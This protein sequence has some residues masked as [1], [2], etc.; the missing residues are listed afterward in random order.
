MERKDYIGTFRPLIA[1][2]SML[3]RGRSVEKA[4]GYMEA[5]SGAVCQIKFE[6]LYLMGHL[7]TPLHTGVDSVS[8][9]NRRVR[10][11]LR[12]PL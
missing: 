12:V 5:Q 1:G 10:G 6:L 11:Y 3:A 7:L 8:S 9:I 2:I 4:A